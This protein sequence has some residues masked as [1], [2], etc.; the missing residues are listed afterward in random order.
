MEEVE[1]TCNH[2]AD[3]RTLYFGAAGLGNSVS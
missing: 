2:T 1:D 3:L